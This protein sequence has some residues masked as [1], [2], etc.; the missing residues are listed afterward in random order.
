MVYSAACVCKRG[1]MCPLSCCQSMGKQN[2]IIS[3]ALVPLHFI[4]TAAVHGH[5]L[6]TPACFLFLPLF[7]VAHVWPHCTAPHLGTD[8][9][10]LSSTSHSEMC[11]AL[12][13]SQKQGGKYTFIGGQ[14]RHAAPGRPYC[15]CKRLQDHWSRNARREAWLGMAKMFLWYLKICA[16]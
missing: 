10:T 16:L 11:G 5:L 13:R 12:H 4:R 1:R 2:P 3:A 8:C 6:P 14:H 9:T 7:E 15:V